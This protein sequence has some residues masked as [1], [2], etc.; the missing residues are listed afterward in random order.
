MAEVTRSEEIKYDVALNNG[1]VS[2]SNSISGIS[3]F[4]NKAYNVFGKMK[5][6]GDYVFYKNLTSW[7]K[8]VVSWEKRGY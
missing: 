6:N 5:T 8:A 1:T 3:F 4:T 2:C 7:C